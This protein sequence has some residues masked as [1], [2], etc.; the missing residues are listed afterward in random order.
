MPETAGAIIRDALTE[1][2]VQAQ[3]QTLPAVDLNTGIR[4]LN[5]MMAAYYAVGVKLGY[6]KVN[7]PN[8]VVTVPEGVNEGMV[9]NLAMRLASGYDIPV[10]Q[11]LVRSANESLKTMEIIGVKIGNSNFGG[12]LPIGSGNEGSS[13]SYLRNPFYPDCCED[14]NEC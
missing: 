4:Y 9:F 7:S 5:R 13:G 12:T 11:S 10:S 14:I 3:E 8:D 1:L 2:T 6:T